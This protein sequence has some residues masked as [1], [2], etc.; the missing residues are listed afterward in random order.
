MST[1]FPDAYPKPY[2]GAP[3]GV[4]TFVPGHQYASSAPSSTLLD[5]LVS[6]W[7]LDEESG[8]RYDSVGTNHLTDNNTVGFVAGV[9]GNAASFVAANGESFSRQTIP[10]DLSTG[11]TYAAWTRRNQATQ[12]NMIS[13]GAPAW[14]GGSGSFGISTQ[15]IGPPYVYVVFANETNYTGANDTITDELWHLVV[16]WYDPDTKLASI[17]IDGRAPVVA[18]T[19]LVGAHPV[20]NSAGLMKINSATTWAEAGDATQQEQDE[21]AIWSRVLTADERAELYAAGAGKFYP[22]T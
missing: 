10:M 7:K 1:L 6:Y 13:N 12:P 4:G 15:G 8:T 19:A 22:F 16:V 14:F 20:I 11:M 2:P 21:V 18:G 17:Q 9:N 3:S 5:S